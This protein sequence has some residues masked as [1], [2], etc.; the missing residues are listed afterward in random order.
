[1]EQIA[2]IAAKNAGLVKIQ[3]D[4]RR[5]VYIK[6]E[7]T[8]GERASPD[9][10]RMADERCTAALDKQKPVKRRRTQGSLSTSLTPSLTNVFLMMCSR[11]CLSR[12]CAR[13]TCRRLWKSSRER[14]DHISTRVPRFSSD[15]QRLGCAAWS[16]LRICC[17][18]VAAA[19]MLQRMRLTPC[20]T[21][22]HRG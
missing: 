16:P 3:D 12:R 17:S 21:P 2:A 6:Q 22:G 5:V 14:R 15:G 18:V 8:E 13:G 11:P 19:D 1:M 4:E 10:I 7:K 9:F 20:V